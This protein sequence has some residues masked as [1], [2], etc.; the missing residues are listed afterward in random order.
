MCVNDASNEPAS[1]SAPI[2]TLDAGVVSPETEGHTN[3]AALLQIAEEEG[4]NAGSSS[5]GRSTC[6]LTARRYPPVATLIGV[7]MGWMVVLSASTRAE[8]SNG[9]GNDILLVLAGACYLVARPWVGYRLFF[10]F[11]R[12]YQDVRSRPER[13]AYTPF[14]RVFFTVQAVFMVVFVAVAIA[15]LVNPDLLRTGQ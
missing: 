14:A 10:Q 6:K 13:Q 1:G 8:S 12:E 4:R 5:S 9:R 7:G 15:N 2:G 3:D 11:D